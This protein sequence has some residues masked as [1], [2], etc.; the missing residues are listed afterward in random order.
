MKILTDVDGWAFPVSTITT[1]KRVTSVNEHIRYGICITDAV[2]KALTEPDYELV[3][4]KTN[5]DIHLVDITKYSGYDN[6][7]WYWEKEL[8]E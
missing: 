1:L 8:G 7:L 4:V 6:F 2:T 5:T 3:I